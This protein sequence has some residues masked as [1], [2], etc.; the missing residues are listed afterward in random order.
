MSSDHFNIE[1]LSQEQIIASRKK[2]GTNTLKL[3]KENPFIQAFKRITKEP[4]KKDTMLQA[5]KVLSTTFFNWK[6]LSVSIL[7]G[8]L[9]SFG[10]LFIYQFAVYHCYSEA[11][12]RTMVFTTLI[13]SNIFLTLISRSFHDSFFKTIRYKNN[14][15]SY[16]ITLTIFSVSLL[17]FVKPISL[18]F[19]FELLNTSQLLISIG[20]GFLSVVWFELVKWY[21][22]KNMIY[23]QL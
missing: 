6:E 3:K 23:S 19:E 14:L 22:R 13:T 12:T 9:I 16:I 7:Q 17:L 18:F 8:F 1:G 11:T 4:M 10:T 15:V 20:V 2:N 21:K 5:P